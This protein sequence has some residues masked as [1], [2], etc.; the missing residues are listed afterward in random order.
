MSARKECRRGQSQGRWVL[1][2]WVAFWTLST[3]IWVVVAAPERVS[4]AR[5]QR[6]RPMT[7]RCPRALSGS[8]KNKQTALSPFLASESFSD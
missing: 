7:F 1:S 5:E 8:P 2:M 4:T 3:A 6:R